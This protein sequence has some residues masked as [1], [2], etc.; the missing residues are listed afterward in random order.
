M[1]KAKGGPARVKKLPNATLSEP[2]APT[3]VI[4]FEHQIVTLRTERTM[5][6][7]YERLKTFVASNTH[8]ELTGRILQVA[9]NYP[10]VFDFLT[11]DGNFKA[12]IIKSKASAILSVHNARRA[13][14]EAEEQEWTPLSAEAAVK[15]AADMVQADWQKWTEANPDVARMLIF[16][17]EAYPHNVAALKLGIA[18]IKATAIVDSST[19]YYLELQHEG[20]DA[21]DFWL[22]YPATEVAKYCDRFLKAFK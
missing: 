19:S 14:M 5:R 15:A 11:E 7:W 1:A 10:E 17:V 13:A 6:D 8:G 4:R 16:N 20:A 2:L 9:D 22:D 12:D 3:K 21:H 18:C